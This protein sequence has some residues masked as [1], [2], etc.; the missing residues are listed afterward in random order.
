M[1][2][3]DILLKWHL[4]RNYFSSFNIHILKSIISIVLQSRNY[5]IKILESNI[6]KIIHTIINSIGISGKYIDIHVESITLILIIFFMTDNVDVENN[7]NEFFHISSSWR[8]IFFY[9]PLTCHVERETILCISRFI[10]IFSLFYSSLH[11]FKTP[12]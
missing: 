2:T 6:S 10:Y 1:L 11:L 12:E 3:Y 7:F 9:E 5:I 8:L 4:S